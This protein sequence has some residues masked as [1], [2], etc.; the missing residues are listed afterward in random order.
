MEKSSRMEGRRRQIAHGD[1]SKLVKG[2][3]ELRCQERKQSRGG[4]TEALAGALEGFYRERKR[5]SLFET[6]TQKESGLQ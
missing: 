4:A 1:E 6:E 2:N 5:H 3:L